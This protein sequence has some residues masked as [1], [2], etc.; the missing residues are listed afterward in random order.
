[1][2]KIKRERNRSRI[3]TEVIY[4]SRKIKQIGILC[5]FLF[6]IFLNL[7]HGFEPYNTIATVVEA[8]DGDTILALIDD[9]PQKL[10]LFGID[11][12]EVLWGPK[13]KWDADICGVSKIHMGSLGQLATQYTKTLLHKDDQIKATIYEKGIDELMAIVCLP[14]GTCLNERIVQDGY[15]CVSKKRPKLLPEADFKKLKEL[16]GEAKKNKYGLWER[17]YK[18]MECLCQYQWKD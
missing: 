5:L 1:M 17:A 6:F 18:T 12:P 13:L 7:T 14:D 10:G 2:Y 9:E 15:A 4:H 3:E 11:A 8:L 16:L